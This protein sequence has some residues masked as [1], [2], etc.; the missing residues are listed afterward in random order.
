MQGLEGAFIQHRGTLYTLGYTRDPKTGLNVMLL[1]LL[2]LLLLRLHNVMPSTAAA[3]AAAAVPCLSDLWNSTV[4]FNTTVD[5]IK[6]G[7]HTQCWT[8]KQVRQP[9]N[10]TPGEQ[11]RFTLRREMVVFWKVFSDRKIRRIEKMAPN[12]NAATISSTRNVFI[13]LHLELGEA[14]CGGFVPSFFW[15][16]EQ[17]SAAAGCEVDESSESERK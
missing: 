10:F 16:W 4:N 7:M 12:D 17:L 9:F 2:L 15:C 1:L 3:A 8:K 14:M 11:S 6:E 5:Q 13:Y